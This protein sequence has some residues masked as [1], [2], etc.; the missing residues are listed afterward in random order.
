MNQTNRLILTILTR[1]TTRR[2]ALV[3]WLF[4]GLVIVAFLYANQR[5]AP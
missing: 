1:V 5:T 2:D 3:L 4:V